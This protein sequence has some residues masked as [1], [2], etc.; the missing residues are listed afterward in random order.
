M[1]VTI[2]KSAFAHSGLTEMIIPQSNV[3]IGKSAFSGC[4][5][6]QNIWLDGSSQLSAIG[7][8]VFF[9]FSWHQTEVLGRKTGTEVIKIPESMSGRLFLTMPTHSAN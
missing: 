6:L 8:H 5:R 9:A 2:E 7:K 1:L 4:K 3:T